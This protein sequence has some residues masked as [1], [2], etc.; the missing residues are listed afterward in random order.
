MTLKNIRDAADCSARTPDV[1]ANRS[2]KDS[3]PFARSLVLRYCRDYFTM[4]FSVRPLAN[5]TIFK[6]FWGA[7]MR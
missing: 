4:T 1:F 7:L 2:G 3:F 6:P 5:L